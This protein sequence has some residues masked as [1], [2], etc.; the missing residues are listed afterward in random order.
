[1][2]EKKSIVLSC[3]RK[4]PKSKSIEQ[5]VLTAS[6]MNVLMIVFRKQVTHVLR[7]TGGINCE[8]AGAFNAS[9]F[10]W[11]MRQIL[12]ENLW[13]LYRSSRHKLSWMGIECSIIS[14]CYWNQ[15]KPHSRCIR[16]LSDRSSNLA[17]NNTYGSFE[18]QRA[19]TNNILWPHSL[20]LLLIHHIAFW[21]FDEPLLCRDEAITNK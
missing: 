9:V 1:M 13:C 17:K 18:S 4:Y 12:Q 3:R 5:K 6:G 10:V 11:D 15:R 14:L 21:Q 2:C 7:E 16:L 19:G 20:T 8:H